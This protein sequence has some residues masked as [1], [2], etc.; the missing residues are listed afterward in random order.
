MD[1]F[2]LPLHS[3]LVQVAVMISI[4]VLQV[5]TV[6]SLGNPKANVFPLVY[7]DEVS[8]VN[9][10]GQKTEQY[11]M[12]THK[13]VLSEVNEFPEGLPTCV[14]T[15]IRTLQDAH[16]CLHCPGC[17]KTGIVLNASLRSAVGNPVKKLAML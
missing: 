3:A 11:L 9:G 1:V 12:D 17:C 7:S 5:T 6:R 4:A 2:C 13:H 16:S 8:L 10:V 14:H 15:G